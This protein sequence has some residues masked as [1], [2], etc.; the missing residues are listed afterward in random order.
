VAQPL[1]DDEPHATNEVTINN[2]QGLHA[3]PIMRFVDLAAQFR[4]RIRVCN[5]TRGGEPLDGKSAFEMMLLEATHGNVLRIE[6]RGPDAQ[7]TVAALA[8]LVTT[9][10]ANESGD[11]AS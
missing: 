6:A 10:L 3:R 7:A 4:S 5:V 8:D 9:T 11:S 1:P 2:S